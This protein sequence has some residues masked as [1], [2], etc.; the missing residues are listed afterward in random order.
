MATANKSAIVAIRTVH[1]GPP[2]IEHAYEAA[3]QTFKKGEPVYL[4]GSGNLAEF[5][6]GIDTGGAKFAGF[7]A[8]DAHND[9]SVVTTRKTQFYPR[10][11]NIF[12]GNIISTGSD[13]VSANTQVGMERPLYRD[14]T[15]SLA[16]VDIANP[17]TPIDSCRI[18]KISDRGA[19]GD[20][21]GR[22]EF[23]LIAAA[24]QVYAG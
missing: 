21:N 1:G 24:M 12:E 15:L 5:T 16:M 23:E 20:T 14:T 10:A 4:D 8:E 22:V 18:V 19:V 11:G 9:A 2:L 6:A 3:S 17:A 7:A 13:I